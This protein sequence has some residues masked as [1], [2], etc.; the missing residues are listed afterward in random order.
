MSR[1]LIVK[2][3]SLGDVVHNLPVVTDILEAQPRTR[4]DWVVEEA[5]ADLPRMHPGVHRVISVAQR[6]WRGSLSVR[7]AAEKRAF[8]RT[9]AEERYDLVIDTQGLVKSGLIV[10]RARLAPGGARV[11]FSRRL[12][13]E[14]LARL[15]YDRGYDVAPHLHAVERLRSL[16]GQALHYTPRGLPRF[17]LAAPNTRF[18]WLAARPYVV[19]LHATSRAEKAWSAKQWRGLIAHF[20]DGGLIPLL[21]HGSERERRAAEELVNGGGRAQVAPRLSL[22]DAAALIQRARA[23]VGVDTG[24]TH[25]AAALEVP[26]VALFGATPRWRYAPYWT[27]QAVSLGEERRQPTLDE[28]LATLAMLRVSGGA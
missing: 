5:Y 13:R 3:S 15:F 8:E 19:L 1:V 7:A 18:D 16:A 11:G 4:I 21:L 20:S 28:V 17:G 2:T 12:A 9:L 25:L 26:T 23:V 24:L 10:R 6:R 14:S 22:A 27:E